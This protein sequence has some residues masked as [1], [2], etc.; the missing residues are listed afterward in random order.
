MLRARR[1]TL[2]DIRTFTQPQSRDRRNPQVSTTKSDYPNVPALHVRSFP[3]IDFEHLGTL[4]LRS[5]I[6]P[7]RCA[8]LNASAF[9]LFSV[10]AFQNAPRSKLLAPSLQRFWS[11]LFALCSLHIRVSDFGFPLFI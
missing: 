8:V 3:E 10:S 7:A 9:Q 5:I 4:M 2:K 11:I 1:S 6:V